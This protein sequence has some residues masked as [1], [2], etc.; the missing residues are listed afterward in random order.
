MSL[1]RELRFDAKRDDS[2]VDG[3]DLVVELAFASAVPYERWWGIEV[4][5]CTPASVRLDRINDSGALLF[6]HDWDALRGHHVPGSVRADA[7]NVVR[8]NVSISWAADEGKTIKLVTGGHLTKT[9]TGYEIHQIIEQ[10]TAKSGEK[11][12]RTLDGQLFDRVLTR[13]N[14]EAPGEL[15]VFRRALDAAAGAF[16]RAA[17]EP[18]TYRVTDWEILENSLVTVPADTSV[19]LGRS[20]ASNEPPAEPETNK[21]SQEISMTEAVETTVDVAAIERAAVAGAM[22]RITEIRAMGKQFKDFDGAMAMAD[23]A[24][25]SGMPAA[26]FTKQL[27]DHISA[28]GIKWNPAT[29]MKPADAQRYSITKAIRA[30]VEGDWSN[31]GFEREMSTDVEQRMKAAGIQRSGTGKGFFIPLEVQR[32]DMLVGTA[33]NGGNMVGTELRPSEFIELMRAEQIAT[34]LGV[35]TLTN[36]VGNLDITKQTGAS[37][38]YWLSTETTAITESQQ[39]IGIVQFRPKTVGA[40]VDVTR[41]LQMQATPDADMLISE[42]MAIQIA[43][44]RDYALINGSGTGGQPTG[45]LATSGIGSVVGTSL[46]YAK[47]IEFQTDVAGANALSADCAY[48]TTNGVAGLLKQRQRFASTDTP[49]WDGNV[50]EGKVD[51][52]SA[53]GTPQMAAATALFGNFRRGVLQAEWGVLE[54][55]VNPYA[56]FAAAISSVRALLTCDVG[57]RIPGAF[58]AAASIT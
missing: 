26:E 1:T 37:T 10:T 15:T 4:L 52:F 5:D 13:C 38:A 20:R 40:L 11:I 43:L 49:L 46:D 50:L 36:L 9:S 29:G 51:G 22:S 25:D 48:V 3:Q 32:R 47:L 35:R 23:A 44:A 33:A 39:T 27:M 58:S 2:L 14:R 6:N 7:D 28:K 19:G 8:G 34:K 17:N 56:N 41:L 42:D 16:E 45:I 30:M 12:E 54:I 53:F 31:A 18:T 24:I 21:S 57:V 55:D